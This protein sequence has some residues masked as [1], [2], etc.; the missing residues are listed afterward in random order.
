MN[1]HGMSCTPT[2]RS[3]AMMLQRCGNPKDPKY[4]IYGANGIRVC[5]SWLMFENFFADMGVRPA[6][7][8]LGRKKN[9]RGY[10]KSN[11]R[12]ETAVEQNNNTA[13]NI[14]LKFDG[15][16]MSL[17]QW[18]IELGMSYTA[19]RKRVKRGWSTQ[20]ALTQPIWVR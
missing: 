17:T 2:Y 19:L 6:G 15:R 11:C 13:Q 3:W 5:R 4:S 10:F 8:S 9:G 7:R 12:W 16:K 18:S 1:R 14:M 20:R